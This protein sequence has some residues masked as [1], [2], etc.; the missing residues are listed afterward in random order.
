M[1]RHLKV[2]TV[3]DGEEEEV[4]HI[5]LIICAELLS[6]EKYLVA[7]MEGKIGILWTCDHVDD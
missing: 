3:V 5:C 1:R 4:A 6:R 7:L 2:I